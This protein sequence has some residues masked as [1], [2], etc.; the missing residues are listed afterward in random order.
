MGQ[1]SASSSLPG[2]VGKYRI[3]SRLGGGGMG[4]VLLAWHPDLGRHVALKLLHE[5]YR[6]D[7][8]LQERFRLEMQVMAQM[9]HPH[10]VRVHD[11]GRD[12]SQGLLYLVM[13]YIQGRDLEQV[14][15]TDGPL[16]IAEACRCVRQAALGLF[17][18]HEK[19]VYHRDVKP[20]NLMLGNDGVVRVMDLGLAR[21]RNL[22]DADGR[23]TE[24]GVLMGTPA[25]MA[26]EQREHP[27]DAD[28]RA[29]IFSLGLTLHYLLSGAL[30]RAA[31]LPA[32]VPPPLVEVIGRMTATAPKQRY[33]RAVEVAAALAPFCQST[34][35]PARPPA[36][37]S[38]GDSVSD[39]ETLP[40]LPTTQL[41]PK[42]RRRWR[43]WAVLA[44]VLAAM[45]T[46]AALLL[47]PRVKVETPNG[48]VVLEFPD[49]IPEDA[50]VLVDGAVVKYQRM[51]D[52]DAKIVVV[53]GEREVVVKSGGKEFRAKDKVVVPKNGKAP[54]VTVAFAGRTSG[55][56]IGQKTKPA[57]GDDPVGPVISMTGHK[58]P[59]YFVTFS[60][61]GLHAVSLGGADYHVWDLAKR[62]SLLHW[63]PNSNS[64]WVHPRPVFASGVKLVLGGA[65]DEVWL[66][67]S[68]TGRKAGGPIKIK[69]AVIRWVDL[70]PDSSRAVTG[71][72][73]GVVCLWN[74]KDGTKL[75]EFKHG[76]EINCTAFSADGKWLLTCC[77]EKIVRLWNLE[78]DKQE[79]AFE[80]HTDTVVAV[81][82][83]SD[84]RK[85]YS[86]A[87]DNTVR[88]WEIETGK[89]IA[90]IEAGGR[91]SPLARAAF[92]PTLHRAVTGHRGGNVIAWDLDTREQLALFSKHK[93]DVTS[94]AISPDGQ[95]ALSGED[96]D[97]SVV[98][99]YRLPPK[100]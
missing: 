73:D 32:T 8:R 21:L 99:L 23:L 72:R 38:R 85:A 61:D 28:G 77:G 5:K 90:K 56:D 30:P 27:E 42:P 29:D 59:G 63:N 98:W 15:R 60:S 40:P 70:S 88:V 48:T 80:G 24:P 26:P 97:D 78:K 93:R 22:I 87:R 83:S 94:V 96:G 58:G 16:P 82:F 4:M 44:L 17:H 50:E 84:G 9:D 57:L 1:V 54:A 55:T 10:L 7:P 2:S 6:G 89:E 41:L 52:K 68:A 14:V 45:G 34:T 47:G 71:S 51:G 95:H 76:S 64:I 62:R 13:E 49:G 36:L 86:A 18:A 31:P 67:D 19:G 100:K 20:S 25:Y 39:R 69:E 74:M 43:I 66:Y 46:T 91:D 33:Q 53:A 75:N 11:G 81:G 79:R 37:P 12:E 35:P 92:C 3:D 65:A